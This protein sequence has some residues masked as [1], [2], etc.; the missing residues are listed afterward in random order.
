[1]NSEWLDIQR[2]RLIPKGSLEVGISRNEILVIADSFSDFEHVIG[3][4]KFISEQ[5][6]V[7][8]GS[9]WTHEFQF[10][11]SS[12]VS[13]YDNDLLSKVGA[14]VI[15][16]DQRTLVMY[17]N[18]YFSNSPLEYKIKSN[19]DLTEVNFSMSSVNIL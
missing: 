12:Y 8:A 15:Y 4:A 11:S 9:F 19:N 1:M 14:I 18:D 3:T 7:N 16:T 6:F 17:Q 5:K 10:T 13:G 2:F